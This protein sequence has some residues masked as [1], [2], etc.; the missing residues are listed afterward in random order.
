MHKL[1]WAPHHVSHVNM[2][3]S[4]RSYMGGWRL[5]PRDSWGNIQ[6]NTRRS[7]GSHACA[8]CPDLL[9]RWVTPRTPSFRPWTV[10]P[11][12]HLFCPQSIFFYFLS[13]GS[14]QSGADQKVL[15]KILKILMHFHSEYSKAFPLAVSIHSD[16]SLRWRVDMRCGTAST[17]GK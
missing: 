17:R 16:S 8:L 13:R 10:N 14:T 12:S 3:L 7:V 4:P 11:D 15:S 9:L 1:N 2:C 6:P 5:H